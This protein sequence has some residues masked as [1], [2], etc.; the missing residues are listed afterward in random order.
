MRT[1][2]FEQVRIN[3]TSIF[4]NLDESVEI[5][6]RGKVVGY[7]VKNININLEHVSKNA[8]LEQ[9]QEY[10]DKDELEILNPVTSH[11][12]EKQ[13]ITEKTCSA[14]VVGT[15]KKK[16]AN[17]IKGQGQPFQPYSKVYQTRKKGAA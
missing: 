4:N 10:N 13:T 17:I 16:I 7:I 6:K 12:V 5:T 2:T 14:Q 9:K 15:L 3:L 11:E 1:L 8:G